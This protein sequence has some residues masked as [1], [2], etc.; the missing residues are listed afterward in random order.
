MEFFSY[1]ATILGSETGAMIL[2]LI[3]TLAVAA[4]LKHYFNNSGDQ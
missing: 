2:A 3:L 1:L 4:W